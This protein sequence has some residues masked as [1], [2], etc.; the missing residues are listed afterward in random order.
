MPASVEEG[1]PPAMTA[2]RGDAIVADLRRLF[3]G[4]RWATRLAWRANPRLLLGVATVVLV[5]GLIPAAMALTARGLVNAT[6]ATI[7]GSGEIDLLIPWLVAGFL[8]TI[9]EGVG[10]L[11]S[12]LFSRR[13]RD[14]LN[15]ILTLDLLQ[16][17]SRL[18]VALYD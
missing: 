5:R 6:V 18:D 8:L 9:A 17:A 14:D 1:A 11:A 4:A 10:Q 15:Y 3:D 7:R 2:A 16:Q 12:D 13:L